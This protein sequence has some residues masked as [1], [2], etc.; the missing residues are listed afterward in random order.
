MHF[1]PLERRAHRYPTDRAQRLV[2]VQGRF[3]IEQAKTAGGAGRAF[4]S[5]GIGNASAEHLITTAKP[6]DQPAAPVMRQNIDVPAFRAQCGQIGDGRLRSRQDDQ[7]GLCRDRLAG[8]DHLQ[9]NTGF[10]F[11]GIKVIEIGYAIQ[12]ASR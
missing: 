9:L 1:I 11:Q 10:E 5:I 2:P 8:R 7:P 12:S 6:Q 4:L 3:D